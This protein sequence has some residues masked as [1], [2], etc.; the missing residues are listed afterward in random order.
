MQKTILAALLGVLLALSIVPA[1]AGRYAVDVAVYQYGVLCSTNTVR[2]G[3]QF[4]LV[5]SG[6][7]TWTSA[8]ICLTGQYPCLSAQVDNSS[9]FEQA[10]L[11]YY[12]GT[13]QVHVY[14]MKSRNGG[15]SDLVYSGLL[16][17]VN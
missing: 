7:R 5:G 4:T 13:Y 9:S 12:P 16:T 2:V 8:K 1:S 11:L 15:N 10:E 14:Q 3:N 6:F 17:V